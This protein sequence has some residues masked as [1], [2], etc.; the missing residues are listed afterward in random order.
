RPRRAPRVRGVDEQPGEGARAPV[1]ATPYAPPEPTQGPPAPE[2]PAH[3]SW[4][5]AAAGGALVLAA[6]ALAVRVARRA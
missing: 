1:W 2:P 3:R 5:L 4:L 6:G